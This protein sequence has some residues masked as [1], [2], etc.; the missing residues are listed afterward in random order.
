MGIPYETT[1]AVMRE[2]LDTLEQGELAL[3]VRISPDGATR[4]GSFDHNEDGLIPKAN[5]GGRIAVW[6]LPE[7]EFHFFKAFREGLFDLEKQVPTFLLQMAF[8]HAH[9][10]FET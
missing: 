7:D 6:E 3:V 1:A 4:I 8:V 5:S 10:L 2:R 9:T